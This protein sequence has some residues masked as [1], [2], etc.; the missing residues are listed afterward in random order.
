MYISLF[1]YFI[2]TPKW[3]LCMYTSFVFCFFFYIKG[4]FVSKIIWNICAGGKGREGACVRC[5]WDFDH[6][7]HVI[8]CWGHMFLNVLGWWTVSPAA[9]DNAPV[10][11]PHPSHGNQKCPEV[12][13]FLWGT[14]APSHLT[15][16]LC[17]KRTGFLV[18][19]NKASGNAWSRAQWH[20][21]CAAQIIIFCV[22]VHIHIL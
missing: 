14:K 4:E 13:T 12:A 22:S 10:T 6:W 15:E 18:P 5:V 8:L 17:P 9:T 3:Y 2:Y 21:G 7:G 20:P 11:P 19:S 1:S 16:N